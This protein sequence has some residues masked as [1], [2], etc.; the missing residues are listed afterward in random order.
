MPFPVTCCRFGIGVLWYSNSPH[1]VTVCKSN[2]KIWR[3]KSITGLQVVTFIPQRRQC[4]EIIFGMAKVKLMFGPVKLV[5]LPPFT[6]PLT[7]TLSKAE[8]LTI[9]FFSSCDNESE[10][11]RIKQIIASV[12]FS[13]ILNLVC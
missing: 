8:I 7:T 10:T 9:D 5:K 2:S 4:T 6:N 13:I 1:F 12:S 3:Y 11:T